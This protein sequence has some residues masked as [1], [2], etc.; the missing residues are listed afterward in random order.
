MDTNM[1]PMAMTGT[2]HE[3]MNDMRCVPPNM[4]TAVQTT[5]AIPMTT[6]DIPW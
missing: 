1:Y 5:A 6:S 4:T 2:T 3:V